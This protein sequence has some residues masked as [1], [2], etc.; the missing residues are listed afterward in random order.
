[1]IYSLR[2]GLKS[3]LRFLTPSG[4]KNDPDHPGGAGVLSPLK[5]RP[6]LVGSDAKPIPPE[7]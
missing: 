2:S 3:L 5:P 4:W 7:D 1:M 6:V